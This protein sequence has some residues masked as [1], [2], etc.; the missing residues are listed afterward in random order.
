MTAFGWLTQEFGVY[1]SL[2]GIASVLFVTAVVA[3]GI[4]RRLQTHPR[5][6]LVELANR[7]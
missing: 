2:F 1:A 7:R 5:L 6:T 4:G 3:A